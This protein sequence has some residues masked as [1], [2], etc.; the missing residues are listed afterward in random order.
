MGINTRMFQTILDVGF[1]DQWNSLPIPQT[2]TNI[3]G[4]PHVGARS[5][6]AVGG[7]GLFLHYL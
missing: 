4:E 1:E 5:L 2:D 6:D 7:L 3:N